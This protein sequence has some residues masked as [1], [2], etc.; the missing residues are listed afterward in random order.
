MAKVIDYYRSLG[1]E[2]Q[3]FLARSLHTTINMPLIEKLYKIFYS[4]RIAR[5]SY[6]YPKVITIE[7]CNMCNLCCTMCPYPFMTREKETMPMDLYT[8]IV[9][10]ASD[11][12][13]RCL[14]LTNYGEP[15][16][17]KY[18]FN[19]IEYAKAKG[20]QVGF[21]S[22]GTLLGKNNNIS[23]LLKSDVDWI[24]FSVDGVTKKT[25]EKIR[26]GAKFDEVAEGI[27]KLCKER[28]GK[29]KF[30]KIGIT[31]CVQ[32]DNLDE[33]RNSLGVFK[34]LFSEV[35]YLVY[36]PKIK[37]GNNGD[38]LPEDKDFR[39]SLIAP[40]YVYPCRLPFENI[41]V[42]ADGNVTI[43]CM[44][45]EGVVKLG[46]LNITTIENVWNS[47]EYRKIKASH[48][49]GNGRSINICKHCNYLDIS[50]FSWWQ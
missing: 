45:Y 31:C 23:R 40:R 18:L 50:D 20:M 5:K 21:T 46:D 30:P 37:R 19:R 36:G 24:E 33:I 27:T 8:R 14:S 16:L 2:K 43:C 22:N 34:R 15:F 3:K 6:G 35:D 42:L 26:Q 41:I 47:E 39:R 17:D 29:N 28:G 13:I 25:Y 12:G 44:D 7:T 49:S 11:I 38:P 48:L 4:R 10:N 1:Y 32:E 9:D